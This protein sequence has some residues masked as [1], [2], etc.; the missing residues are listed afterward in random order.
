MKARVLMQTFLQIVLISMFGKQNKALSHPWK[1]PCPNFWNMWFIRLHGKRK[2]GLQRELMLQIELKFLMYSF[3]LYKLFWDRW[4]SIK[5]CVIN[6]WHNSRFES[7]CNGSHDLLQNQAR[8]LSFLNLIFVLFG[9]IV[10]IQCYIH[11]KCKVTQLYI[12]IYPFFSPVGL[13]YWVKLLVL[14]SKSL[15]IICFIYSSVCILIPSS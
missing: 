6:N 2:L 1:C 9:G 13:E 14:Y 10:Y 4:L 7:H 5:C 3:I 12:Q 8:I 11:F 15:L